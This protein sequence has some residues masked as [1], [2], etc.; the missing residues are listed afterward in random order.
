[1]LSFARNIRCYFCFATI[2]TVAGITIPVLPPSSLAAPASPKGGQ[3]DIVF[4]AT[5]DK[6][7][8]AAEEPANLA[9]ALKNKG[10]SPVYVNKRFYFGPEDA[11]KNQKGTTVVAQ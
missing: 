8:Y 4:T 10:K 7:E 5:L 6:A 11:P 9:F 1:M 3:S 2:L